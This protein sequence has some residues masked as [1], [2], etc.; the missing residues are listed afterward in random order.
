MAKGTKGAKQNLGLRWT[1]LGKGK[2]PLHLT[3]GH[4]P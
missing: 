3:E 4:S 1:Q 2:A